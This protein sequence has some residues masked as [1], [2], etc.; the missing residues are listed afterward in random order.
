MMYVLM[1]DLMYVLSDAAVVDE[2]E[3]VDVVGIEDHA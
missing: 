3:K 1:V 2:K